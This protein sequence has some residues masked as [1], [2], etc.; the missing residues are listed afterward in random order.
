MFARRLL[1]PSGLLKGTAYAG[2][3]LAGLL[4]SQAYYVKVNFTLPPDASGPTAGVAR[5]GQPPP[6]KGRTHGEPSRKNI[7]FMGDSVVK[8]VGCRRVGEGPTLPRHVAEV[9]AE[10]LGAEVGWRALGETGADIRMLREQ[11]IPLLRREVERCAQSGERVD[12][13]VVVCGLN[14]IKECF[15]YANPRRHPGS[16]RRSL[17]ELVDTIHEVA[18]QQC[19]VLLPACPI[20]SSPRF[21]RFW[22]LSTLVAQSSAAWERQKRLLAEEAEAQ[23]QAHPNPN[24]NPH[25]QPRP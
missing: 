17:Q 10:Q 25:P 4:A 5:A 1:S 9:V 16:F 2:C 22:P 11:F 15:L 3:G 6:P 18:G 14:D 7:V 19:A 20:D 8:G 21:N 13:V 23:P 12:A 24:P